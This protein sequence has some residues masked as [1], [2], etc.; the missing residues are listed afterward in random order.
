MVWCGVS[1]HV[2]R[3]V[4]FGVISYRTVSRHVIRR[5][6]WRGFE[7]HVMSFRVNIMSDHVMN[8]VVWSIKS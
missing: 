6:V 2:V 5:V 8:G 7:C 4:A 3:R 1:C